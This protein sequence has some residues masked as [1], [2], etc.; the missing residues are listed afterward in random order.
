[1]KNKGYLI[2]ELV[3]SFSIATIIAIFLIDTALDMKQVGDKLELETLLMT[4]QSSLSKSLQ[5]D[6]SKKKI[7]NLNVCDSDP[8]QNTCCIK[9]TY[10]DFITKKIMIDKTKKTFTYGEF[11]RNLANGSSYGDIKLSL[12]FSTDADPKAS[13]ALI[14]FKVGVTNPM[15]KDKDYGINTIYLYNTVNDPLINM[16]DITKFNTICNQ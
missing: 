10:N 3:I 13:N 4:T 14:N 12:D 2:F 15:I 9:I 16:I 6:F 1:M 11:T 5:E 7:T 8:E